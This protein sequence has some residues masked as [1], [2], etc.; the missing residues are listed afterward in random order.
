MSDDVI[1]WGKPKLLPAPETD[2]DS[3]TELERWIDDKL[4]RAGIPRAPV[5]PLHPSGEPEYETPKREVGP[6]GEL[7]PGIAEL[8]EREYGCRSGGCAWRGTIHGMESRDRNRN[9]GG[10][11]IGLHCPVCRGWIRDL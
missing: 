4:E 11:I 9:A 7:P 1:G 10:S 5:V 6:L 8:H 2:P 3:R